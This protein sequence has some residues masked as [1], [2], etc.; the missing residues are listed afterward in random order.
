M[1]GYVVLLSTYNRVKYPDQ[2]GN[3]VGKTCSH[4]KFH[5]HV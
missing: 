4:Q 2:T 5:L 3:C 1:R